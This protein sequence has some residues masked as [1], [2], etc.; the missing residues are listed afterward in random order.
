FVILD[1]EHSTV[2]Y[3][4]ISSD[5]GSSDVGSP[6]VIVLGYVGLPMMPEDPYAYVEAA[7]QEPPPEFI[8]SE[9]DVLPIADSP[10]YI[11][12][13]DL[14]EDPEE[15]DDEDPGEDPADY[16]TNKD[17]DEEESSRDDVDDEEEDEGEDEE[18]EEHLALADSVDRLL[19]I[20]TPPP[21]PLTSYSSPLPHILSPPLPV[22]SPLPISPSPL[23]ASP[24]YSL[25]YRA[26]M[27][28]LRAE[29]PSTFHP[30]P[31]PPPIILLRTRASIS[32]MRATVPSTYY[33][34]P[35]LGTP[36]ILPIPLPTS[37][38]PLL[39]PSTDCRVDVPEVTLPPRKRLCIAPGPRFE[40]G[41]S[42]SAPTDRSIGGFRADYD[43]DEIAQEIPAT[44]VAELGQRMIDFVT[45][46]RQDTYEI[47]GRLDDAQDDRSLMSASREAWVQSMDA[48]DTVRYEVRALQTMV[49][50]QQTEIG[51]LWAADRRRQV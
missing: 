43:P 22:S 26:A 45:T 46:V 50:A 21:S 23:P 40:I 30:L 44:D 15:E 48:S 3:T 10:S 29:S 13:S 24:T 32:M 33:L 11:T 27:I 14:E 2:T 12:E 31:L 17:D 19:A 6:G 20:S 8:P 47:Y 41:E 5:D 51:D 36:P 39:L 49:L 1:S 34:A 28:R 18:E 38:P 25:G 4:S 9:D 37:S 35:P 7:M 42:S 16:P